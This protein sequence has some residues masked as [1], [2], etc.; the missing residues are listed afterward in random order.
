MRKQQE[1]SREVLGGPGTG[2]ISTWPPICR[3]RK[4][5]CRNEDEARN[6]AAAREAIVQRLQE[7]LTTGGTTSLVG[8]RGD[9]R[10]V[11]LARGALRIDEEAVAADARFDGKLVLRTNTDLPAEEVAQTYKSLWRVERTVREEK[12][13]LPV[14]PLFHHRDDTSIGHIVASCL[15]L[16][17]DVDLQ[18]RLEA[19]GIEVSWPTLMRDLGQVHA[20]RVE[21]DGKPRLCCARTSPGRLPRPLWRLGCARPHRSRW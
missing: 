8:N 4:C 20:V 6:D 9:A 12:S 13:T 19:T 17:L 7:K 16:R 5:A 21:L 1:I 11:T 2:A 18:R 14:R 15:A 10:R 3:C